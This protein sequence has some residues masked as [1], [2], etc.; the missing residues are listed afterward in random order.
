VRALLLALAALLLCLQGVRGLWDPDEGRYAATAWRMLETGDWLTPHLSAGVPH[1]TKPPLTYW[2]LAA[3]MGV[4]GRNEWAL[5][6]PLALAGIGTMALAYALARRLA[7]RDP[8][9]AAAIQGTSLLPFVGVH[10]VTTDPFLMLFETL[11]VWGFVV[12]WWDEPAPRWAL[13][14]MWLGFALAFLTKGPP[15]LLP[16]L[17]I[18]VFAVWSRG[19][20]GLLRVLSPAGLLLFALVACPWFL[21]QMRAHPDLLDYFLGAEVEGRLA[22]VHARNPGWRGWCDAVGAVLVAGWLPWSG[23]ALVPGL[24]ALRARRRRPS[25]PAAE[26]LAGRFLCLWLGLPLLV[27]SL[28]QSRQPLYLLPLAVPGSLLLARTLAPSWRWTR[29]QRIGLAAWMMLLV[30]ITAVASV[31]DRSRDGRRFAVRLA[32]LLERPPQTILFVD[33]HALY[34]LAVYFDCDVRSV[35]LLEDLARRAG[36]AYQPLSSSLDDELRRP[37][38]NAVWLVR[39][40]SL[41]TW[42]ERLAAAG[43][44]FRRLGG[45]EDY[46]A[47]VAHAPGD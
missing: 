12:A 37:R 31:S 45:I 19:G 4:L 15:G 2:V 6:L 10:I 40:G 47:Y 23:R 11:A 36:P 43:W 21:L 27:F 32:P 44:R 26:P 35:E 17:P 1:F 13:P 34:S 20:R 5:R 38:P 30:L 14:A 25:S 39:A 24:R 33:R 29:R 46:H 8:L 16:L 18:F 9:L 28:A 41:F 3:S 7:P 22:G 42:Q